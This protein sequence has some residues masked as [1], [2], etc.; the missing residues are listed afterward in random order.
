MFI[1]VNKIYLI[2]V[3]LLLIKNVLLIKGGF[4]KNLLQISPL[5]CCYMCIVNQINNLYKQ[6][7][8]TYQ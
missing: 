2:G 1:V 3:F 8:F 4:D 5:K 7:N 6:K